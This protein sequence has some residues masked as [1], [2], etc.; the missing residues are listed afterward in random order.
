MGIKVFY[1]Y[2]GQFTMSFPATLKAKLNI[3]FLF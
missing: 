3:D 2:Y 1:A